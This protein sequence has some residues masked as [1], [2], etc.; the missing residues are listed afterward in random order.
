MALEQV[1]GLWRQRFGR[2]EPSKIVCVGLN[3]HDHAAEQGVELPQAPLLFAKFANT[4]RGS[5]DPIVLP[6]ESEHVDAEAELAIVIG[7][8]ARRVPP[9][10]RSPPSRATHARTM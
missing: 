8:E 4:L 10:T 6:P 3:Y 2:S 7:R 9:G 5:G 1:R